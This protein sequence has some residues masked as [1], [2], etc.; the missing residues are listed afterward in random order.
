MRLSHLVQS[1]FRDLAASR[2]NSDSNTMLGNLELRRN[3][4]IQFG[5]IPVQ[6]LARTQ[7]EDLVLVLAGPELYRFKI[8]GDEVTV[9]QIVF[10]GT[11]IEV[12][13]R[14]ALEIVYR[15][16]IQSCSLR[17]LPSRRSIA[18]QAPKHS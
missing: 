12:H 9:S 5:P 15:A 7:R 1:P 3:T 4:D 18:P 2:K 10:E 6:A 14:L 13:Q 16:N 17:L 11:M 8:S